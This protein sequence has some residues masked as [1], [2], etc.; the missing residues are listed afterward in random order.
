MNLFLAA[1][2]KREGEIIMCKKFVGRRISDVFDIIVFI[3]VI[4]LSFIGC[5]TP[6]GEMVKT[7]EKYTP[8]R[9]RV[10][11]D[12][13]SSNLAKATWYTVD[14]VESALEV[15]EQYVDIPET[16][17]VRSTGDAMPN[18][19]SFG[20][21]L[22]DDLSTL[23]R[24][25]LNSVKSGRSVEDMEDSGITLQEELKNIL[26]IYNENMF[27]LVPSIE[28]LELGYGYVVEDDIVY[29]PGGETVSLYS[30]ENIPV[31]S[32]YISS[33]KEDAKKVKQESPTKWVTKYN[34]VLSDLD[35]SFIKSLY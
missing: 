26:S 22:P 11:V 16:A 32:S 31:K 24:K 6:M 21:F 27:L 23:K 30:Y 15:I 8:L 29:V 34:T 13:L 5:N 2:K 35:K 28:D 17:M 25:S 1:G 19:K 4:G 18:L 20:D 14:S 9:E 12:T 7:E 33:N 10:S 3:L